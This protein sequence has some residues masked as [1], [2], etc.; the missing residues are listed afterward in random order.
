MEIINS[1]NIKE[2][3]KSERCLVEEFFKRQERLPIY[4]RS[5]SCMISCPCRNCSPATL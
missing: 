1:K 4:Q 3:S 2:T 5:K